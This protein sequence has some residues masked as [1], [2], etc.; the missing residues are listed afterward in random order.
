MDE[1]LEEQHATLLVAYTVAL[2]LNNLLVVTA[3]MLEFYRLRLKNRKQKRMISYTYERHL[4]R[5]VNFR[6]MVFDSDL[7]CME[8][9]R[10]N[11]AAFY[12]LCDMSESIGRLAPMK[13]MNIKEMVA[14]FLYIISHH[15]KNRIV[16]RE[17][18]RSGETI[19]RQFGLILLSILRLHEDL[20]KKPDLN[21]LGALDGTYIKVNVPEVGKPRYMTRKGEIATNVL[22]FA[23]DSRVLTN[24]IS[25][26]NGLKVPQGFYYLCDAGYTNE[27]RFL[28]PYRGQRY[29]LNE[30]RQNNLSRS[31]EELFNYKHSSARN[32]I[33]ICFGLLKMRWGILR[34]RS[35]YPVKT[36]WRIISACALLH[37]HIRREMAL[38][39]LEA[40]L[41]ESYM[42][43]HP[44]SDAQSI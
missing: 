7:T 38:D 30:W 29:H 44:M 5:Q 33:E 37:N 36:H 40:E 12:K 17:F 18:V 28:V 19:S 39:P 32:V 14:L 26:P 3:S 6:R 1:I 25:R 24:A 20:F 8:N 27:E 21:Y 31:Q 13:N 9:I 23:A 41:D 4:I 16:K 10:M 34:D 22:G 2:H 42:D 35:W 15:A 11:I 43:S